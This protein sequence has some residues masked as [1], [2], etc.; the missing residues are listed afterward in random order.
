MPKNTEN[1][2]EIV[3]STNLSVDRQAG[4]IRGVRI[5]GPNSKNRRL[6]TEAAIAK[7]RELY[8][9]RPV[10]ANHPSR[11]APDS[12]RQIQDRIGWLKNVVIADGGYNGDLNVLN[13]HPFTPAILEAAERNPRLFGLSHNVEA[14]TRRE[15]GTT[16]VEEI[17]SVQSVDLVS[18]PA[19]TKSLFEA[20]GGIVDEAP[21]G[22]AG[23]VGAIPGGI[24]DTVRMA[25]RAA[26]MAVVDNV[27]FDMQTIVGKIGELLKARD[28]VAGEPENN[29]PG[30]EQPD[31]ESP[32]GELPDDESPEGDFDD[33][34]NFPTDD[35]EANN[36]AD[37]KTKPT[38][39]QGKEKD[40]K[41]KKKKT[42]ESL[43]PEA[44]Q[45]Q[46][47]TM[48]T[49]IAE[50]KE[51]KEQLAALK[52]GDEPEDIKKLREEIERLKPLA[53]QAEAVKKLQ[54]QLDGMKDLLKES[55]KSGT[56]TEGKKADGKPAENA[57]EFCKAI[58]GKEPKKQG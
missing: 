48:K 11:S 50:V 16:F 3:Q 44:L 29:S 17:L 12:P 56:L 54:E 4:V 34:N 41:N 23:G 25:F 8:E 2:R 53:E 52:A 30:G 9:G 47:E 19:T 18:D 1:I 14:R 7:G 58:T 49:S 13:A 39:A 42:F 20:A 10:N 55:P 46:V 36:M 26:I 40:D 43:T 45:E 21:I 57:A 51:L 38:D 33:D 24:D 6:Y 31:G 22:A 5:L 15:N 35:E 28:I 37:D 32:D 27:A